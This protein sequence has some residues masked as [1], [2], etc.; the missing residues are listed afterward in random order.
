VANATKITDMSIVGVAQCCVNLKALILSG[1]W[2]VTD[3]GTLA[4]H[5]YVRLPVELCVVADAP[6]VCIGQA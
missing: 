4:F 1:C 3:A 6:V 5:F 2:K